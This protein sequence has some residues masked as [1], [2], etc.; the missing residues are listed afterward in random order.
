MDKVNVAEAF[1]RCSDLWSPK[2]VA[3]CDDYDVK[4]AKVKGEFVWH[5]HEETDEL[6]LVVKGKV[7]IRQR[8]RD[9]ELGEGELYVVPRGVEH[10]PVADDETHL[11]VFVRKGTVNTGNLRNERTVVA[12]QRLF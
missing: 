6:F 2:I 8:D 11:L 7:R 12:D 5:H 10:C 9:V 3:T 4:L 1:G